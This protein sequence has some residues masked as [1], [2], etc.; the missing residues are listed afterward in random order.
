MAVSSVSTTHVSGG[1]GNSFPYEDKVHAKIGEAEGYDANT[2][3]LISSYQQGKDVFIK[4]ELVDALKQ[5]FEE[6]DEELG[7]VPVP[8][9]CVR[10]ENDQVGSVDPMIPGSANTGLADPPTISGTPVG[11]RSVVIRVS[12]AGALGTAEYRKSEDGGDTFGPLLVTPVSGV[13]ALAVGVTATFHN[14]TPLADTFHVGDTFRF[15]INGPGPSEQSRLLAIQALKTVDQGNTPFYWF[16]HLGGVS[17]SFAVSVAVLLEEMRT[18]NLF[19][20]FAVLETDRKTDTESIESY[21][22]RIQDEWDSFV[23]ERVCVVGAEGRYIPG[24]I[25]SQGGWNASLEFAGAIGEWRN[26]AT[27]LCA[28]LA[29]HRVNVSAAWV[30]KN[31]SRTFIGIR[32]WNEGYKGYQ[33]AFDDLGLTILQ[34]YPDYQGV[35]IASDNLMAGAT[36]DFQYIP[37]LR[38]ANKMHRVVYRESLPFLKSDTETNSGSGGLDY[39]KAVIDAKVSSEMERAGEAEISG[40]EI[41]LQP[42]KTVNGRKVLPATLKMFIKDRIDAIQWSTEFALA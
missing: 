8:V 24:G 16:H 29:A 41:K 25:E 17:R 4:G 22:L 39:L 19:R 23:N 5:H 1:L 9:L 14:D 7:E 6:F 26:A 15:N 18:Q 38:R 40:H 42:I 36:S 21:F 3:I 28:R 31:K 2:P 32:Y 11:N 10:P 34:I 13:I 35:F 30:A 33:T 12:K 37:E 20:I 27:F